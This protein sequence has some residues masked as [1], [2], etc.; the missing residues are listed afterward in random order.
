[1]FV[2]RAWTTYVGAIMSLVQEGPLAFGD[3]LALDTRIGRQLGTDRSDDLS[4]ITSASGVTFGDGSPLT[5]GRYRRHLQIHMNPDSGSQ[6]AAFYNSV[7]TGR[8]DRPRRGD[9][10]AEGAE[11]PV[12]YTAAHMAGFIFKKKQLEETPRISERPRFCRSGPAPTGSL[13]SPRPIMSSSKPATTTGG[14]SRWSNGSPSRRSRPADPASRH[15][16]RRYRRHLR[17]RYLRH[18]PV[19]GARQCRRHHRAVARHVRADSRPFGAALRRY[20]CSQGRCLCRG[21][22]GLVKALLKGNGE[23][24]TA[25]EP[26]GDVVGRARRRRGPGL[27]RYAAGYPFDLDKAKAELAQSAIRTAS[28]SP[29]R[30]RPPIPIWSTSCRAWRRI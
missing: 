19:E 29:S 27:L 14:R 28:T 21:P 20:P 2:P 8:G 3:D 5:A 4:N 24:A 18:R 10:Q 17:S 23:A 13:N 11:C 26:A 15:A 30:L 12:P 6:L 16:E 1:M 22:R 25:L 7:A 9:R